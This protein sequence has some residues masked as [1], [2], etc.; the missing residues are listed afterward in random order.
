MA[1]WLEAVSYS[2]KDH[3]DRE[4]EQCADEIIDLIARAQQADG[5][6][7]TYYHREIDLKAVEEC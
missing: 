6:L 2:L 5:Y 1:K 4:L 7:N 3:P